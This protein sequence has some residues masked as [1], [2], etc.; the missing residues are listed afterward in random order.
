MLLIID[1]ISII[2]IVIIVII[3]GQFSEIH[4]CFCGLDPG[5]LKFEAVRT[6]KKHICF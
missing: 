6:D 1:I 5:I 2:I 3:Y 4:V